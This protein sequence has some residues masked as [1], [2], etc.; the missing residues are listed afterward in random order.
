MREAGNEQ[1]MGDLL[2]VIFNRGFPPTPGSWFFNYMTRSYSTL[3]AISRN[4]FA[5]W[6]LLSW[7]PFRF[8]CLKESISLIDA[9]FPLKFPCEFPPSSN[10]VFRALRS[11]E[12]D[13]TQS[14]NCFCDHACQLLSPPLKQEQ[15]RRSVI[16]TTPRRITFIVNDHEFKE[17]E[18]FPVG[19]AWSHL[20]EPIIWQL[21]CIN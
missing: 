21:V 9:C 6:L 17:A 20:L 5:P 4:C 16:F 19:G 18:C 14:T 11:W 7:T 3:Q 12:T 8:N 13:A 15:S 10:Y 1:N 2:A